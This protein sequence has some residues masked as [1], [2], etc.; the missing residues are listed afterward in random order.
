MHRV[1][2]RGEHGDEPEFRRPSR[3]IANFSYSHDV[4]LS[5]KGEIIED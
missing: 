1:E 2:S 4:V 5:D 3:R